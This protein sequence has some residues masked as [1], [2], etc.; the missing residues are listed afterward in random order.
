LL[1]SSATVDVMSQSVVLDPTTLEQ[2]IDSDIIDRIIQGTIILEVTNPFGVGLTGTI[3]IGPTSKPFTIPAAPTASVEISY[4]G[5]ELRSFLA[6]QNPILSGS[7]TA[8]GTAIT[9]A[10]GQEMTLEATLDFT[11]EIG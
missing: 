6:L 10:P 9:I 3:D 11:I 5:A 8:D 4:T 2:D 7:G 1:V